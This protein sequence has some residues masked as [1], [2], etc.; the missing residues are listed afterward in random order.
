MKQARILYRDDHVTVTAYMG[1]DQDEDPDGPDGPGFTATFTEP[2]SAEAEQRLGNTWRYVSM[3]AIVTLND[4][5]ISGAVC[6]GVEHG[7]LD[8]DTDRDAWEWRPADYRTADDTHILGSPLSEAITDALGQAEKWLHTV[9]NDAAMLR[10]AWAWAD[11]NAVH[12]IGIGLDITAD[13][14]LCLELGH[15]EDD[16]T[17][18]R[19]TDERGH[20]GDHNQ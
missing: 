16:G 2:Y 7:H 3:T 10:A 20:D 11:P 5:V 14:V 8:A 15:W 6:Y 17:P 13:W 1:K 19:C 9:G 12:D 18:F 4:V